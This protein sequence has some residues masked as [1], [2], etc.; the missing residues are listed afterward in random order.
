MAAPLGNLGLLEGPDGSGLHDDILQRVALAVDSIGQSAAFGNTSRRLNHLLRSRVPV[1]GGALHVKDDLSRDALEELAAGGGPLPFRGCERLV[2][3][4][5]EGI[6]CCHLYKYVLPAAAKLTQIRT[7]DLCLSPEPFWA[8]MKE[9]DRTFAEFTVS[10][11]PKLQQLRQL[12]LTTTTLG[13]ASA[14]S[15]A[16]LKGLTS[17]HLKEYTKGL[18]WENGGP[19]DLTPLSKLGRLVEFTVDGEAG[20][21]PPAE[22]KGRQRKRYAL[23]RSLR[24]MWLKGD[25]AYWLQHLP[26]CI[27]LEEL[28]ID[29]EG[30]SQHASA[31]P[32]AVLALAA[33]H[34]KGLRQLSCPYAASATFDEQLEGLP[35]T[36]AQLEQ[37]LPHAALETLTS[38]QHLDMGRY[39]S[40]SSTEHW[41]ALGRLSALTTLKGVLVEGGPPPGWRHRGLQQ[42]GAVVRL[43]GEEAAAAAV[44]LSFPAA[45]VADLRGVAGDG[46]VQYCLPPLSGMGSLEEVRVDGSTAPPIA[47]AAA[48]GGP[49]GLPPGLV[50]L[51]VE[52]GAAGGWLQHLP[53]APHLTELAYAYDSE[54]HASTHPAAVLKLA[55][56]RT[57]HLRALTCLRPSSSSSGSGDLE[58]QEGAP[59]DQ[60]LPPPETQQL[61]PSG[62]TLAALTS[63][64]H[65]NAGGY[66]CVSRAADWQALGHLTALSSLQGIMVCQAP[67]YAWRLKHVQQLAVVVEGMDGGSAARVLLG[68]PSVKQARVCVLGAPPEQ[69]PATGAAEG[70]N[71]QQ[72]V[73]P[74][75]S[76]LSSLQLEYPGRY[77]GGMCPAVHAAPLLS[78]ARG[79]EDLCF[80]GECE[81]Q[82]SPPLLPDLGGVTSVTRL[83]FGRSGAGTQRVTAED[84]AAMVQPLG[85]TL[86]VLELSSMRGL[87]PEAVLPLQEVLPRLK[88]VVMDECSTAMRYATVWQDVQRQLRG[89]TIT[90]IARG[91]GH[92]AQWEMY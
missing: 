27:H 25:T 58:Q 64:R 78:A 69:Q 85:R 71:E 3:T 9:K 38:L 92:S 48:A 19:A 31:H 86:R 10:A 63:L 61:L 34:I 24:R 17:L 18:W 80:E 8:F 79:V 56:S 14:G 11:V 40:I 32:A 45:R 23:P 41:T 66:L 44:A 36:E 91:W 49:A 15:V 83:R 21:V 55:A 5:A 75:L 76:L 33:Q 90:M 77:E 82:D 26:A 74:V 43:P 6:G 68:F 70:S 47:A 89:V 51:Q 62:V 28:H 39:L 1:K 59:G 16:A 87:G 22:P 29:Y 20:P 52:G 81:R 42:L 50:R 12:T 67:P 7:L 4:A 2:V 35:D 65:L 13:S 84:L 30:A 53:A 60:Q 57:P 72:G 54:Q 88:Q 37:A 73:P 46:A